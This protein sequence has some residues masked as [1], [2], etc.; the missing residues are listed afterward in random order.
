M[1]ATLLVTGL[2]C[3]D[4]SPGRPAER[5]PPTQDVDSKTPAKPPE[6]PAT[7]RLDDATAKAAVDA[8]NKVRKAKN[9]SLQQRLDALEPLTTGIHKSVVNPLRDAV[10]T[11]KAVTVRKLAAEGLGRQEPKDVRQA[12]TFLLK[13]A[14]V[15]KDI[16]TTAALITA[17]GDTAY[18]TADWPTLEKFFSRE[19]TPD[20]VPLQKAVLGVVTKHKEK[21]AAK[22]LVDHL[23]EPQPVDVHDPSNP[24]AEYW[25][26]R[27][28]CWSA[29]RAD[30][31]EAMF[32]ATGQ[33]FGSGK[34]ARA[35]LR[36]NG[37]KIGIK[38]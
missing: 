19:F 21:Q 26:A 15:T 9:A 7:K 17:L 6:P 23:D 12:L 22:M 16:P 24:P 38:D 32:A 29:W 36:E 28:H 20:T 18:V 1:F 35:W 31:S 14:E 2:L 27:W 37:R 8:W 11:E 13:D 3:Q 5:T 4:P 25:K 33:R 34:E 30:A 10:R